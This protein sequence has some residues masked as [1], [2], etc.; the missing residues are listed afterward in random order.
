MISVHPAATTDRL[1][2]S[3]ASGDPSSRQALVITATSLADVLRFPTIRLRSWK[4]DY[5][6]R[7]NS[8]QGVTTAPEGEGDRWIPV[9]GPLRSLLL[10]SH[11]GDYLHRANAPEGV[12][13]WICGEGN[14]WWLESHEGGV[15]LRSW[16]QDYLHRPAMASGVSSLGDGSSALWT[17]EA[18]A[19]TIRFAA[20]FPQGCPSPAALYHEA[21]LE[22][23]NS[24]G[25]LWCS[26]FPHGFISCYGTG[27]QIVV[28]PQEGMFFSLHSLEI[29]HLNILVA[30]QQTRLIGRHVDGSSTTVDLVSKPHLSSP[31]HFRTPELTCLTA[32]TICMDAVSIGNLVVFS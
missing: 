31:Q 1:L 4:G 13:T 15:R 30:A 2:L 32:L 28:R 5:L 17:L 24:G 8:L 11:K 16:K 9:A 27:R 7:P 29:C 10:R 21:G 22:F 3:K 23:S 14:Q 6:H 18:V 25:N 19:R 20:D 26:P 12:T